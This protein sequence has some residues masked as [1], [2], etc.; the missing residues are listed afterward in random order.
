MTTI[1][2]WVVM[3]LG[4]IGLFVFRFIVTR[5]R[6]L[7]APKGFRVDD[8][9]D[10]YLRAPRDFQLEE[11]A[12]LRP[13][14]TREPPPKD[15]VGSSPLRDVRQEKGGAEVTP[16]RAAGRDMQ[17]ISISRPAK[18]RLV[19]SRTSWMPIAI[20]LLVLLSALYVILS[21][22]AY[23]DPQQKWAFGIVGTILGY[24]FKK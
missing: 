3:S 14:P 18:R 8:R 19:P 24:W 6:S 16:K 17:Q 4:V 2:P 10:V 7:Y 13:S 23:A 9:D 5:R 12:D 22:N 20:S 11:G 1:L 21:K 15:N